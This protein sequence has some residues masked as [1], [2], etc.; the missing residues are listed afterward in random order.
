[1]THTIHTFDRIELHL[2][3]SLWDLRHTPDLFSVKLERKTKSGKVFSVHSRFHTDSS[4]GESD[5]TH[6]V[7]KAGIRKTRSGLAYMGGT[8]YNHA[9]SMMENFLFSIRKILVENGIIPETE[10]YERP[11]SVI[12]F[13]TVNFSSSW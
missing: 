2:Y 12:H 6:L 9:R 5:I 7:T 10:K 8:G 4:Y 13:K 1:M 11:A 3:K